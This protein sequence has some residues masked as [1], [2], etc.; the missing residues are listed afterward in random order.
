M[1]IWDLRWRLLDWSWLLLLIWLLWL[2]AHRGVCLLLRW[3]WAGRWLRSI[4][5][6]IS[7][8]LRSKRLCH[9]HRRITRRWMTIHM[10]WW[11]WRHSITWHW[12][13]H[14]RRSWR[15]HMWRHTW[16]H[17]SRWWHRAWRAIHGVWRRSSSIKWLLLHMWR[18]LMWWSWSPLLLLFN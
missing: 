16:M 2:H 7:A 6:A 15:T 18:K 13:S 3:G 4:W 10:W 11:T 9:W 17:V 12:L 1:S 14:I 5:R 8:S